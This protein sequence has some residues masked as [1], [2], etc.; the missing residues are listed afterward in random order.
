MQKNYNKQQ[1]LFTDINMLISQKVTNH[2]LPPYTKK[3]PHINK[4]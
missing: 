4:F 1:Y 2:K 3:K